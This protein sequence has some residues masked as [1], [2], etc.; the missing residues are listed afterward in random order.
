MAP[1]RRQAIIWTNDGIFYKRIYGSRGLN[2]LIN[3]ANEYPIHS[4]KRNEYA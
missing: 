1:N 4:R 3:A 2:E